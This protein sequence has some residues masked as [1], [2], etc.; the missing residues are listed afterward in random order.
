VQKQDPQEWYRQIMEKYPDA[1]LENAEFKSGSCWSMCSY[2]Y[3]GEEFHVIRCPSDLYEGRRSFTPKDESLLL[4]EVGHVRNH[5]KAKVFYDTKRQKALKACLVAA[6]FLGAGCIEKSK[7]LKNDLL[8]S[9]GLK[10]MR[11][12]SQSIPN[13]LSLYALSAICMLLPLKTM[14]PLLERLNEILADN[15]MCQHAD[16]KALKG[17]YAYFMDHAQMQKRVYG[18]S[19]FIRWL[20]DFAHPASINRAQKIKNALLDRFGETI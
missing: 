16:A 11:P 7:N 2:S 5:M 4:H 1:G 10:E 18:D 8:A 15:F 13:V 3:D 12:L 17:S 6:C 9:A 19:R 14:V 20:N